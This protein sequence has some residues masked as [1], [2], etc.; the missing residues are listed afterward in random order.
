M[1]TCKY[2]HSWIHLNDTTDA[3]F[4]VARKLNGPSIRVNIYMQIY[5]YIHTYTHTYVY[6][7]MYIYVYIYIY[8]YTYTHIYI[9]IHLYI[10][11]RC[12]HLDDTTDAQFS[13]ARELNRSSIWFNVYIYRNTNR[14]NIHIYLA[15]SIY[16]STYLSIY[17]H[18]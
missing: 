17:L 2:T 3:Q 15:L 18:M 6:V 16:L 8:I 10:I 13:V 1:H 14:H 9:Y 12:V 4:P 7:Y 5:T 11:Y